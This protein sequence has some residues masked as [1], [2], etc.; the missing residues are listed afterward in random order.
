MSHLSFYCKVPEAGNP[1]GAISLRSFCK[2]SYFLWLNTEMPQ[3]LQSRGSELFLIFAHIFFYMFVFFRG[4]FMDESKAALHIS[5]LSIQRGYGIFDFFRVREGVLVYVED[6]LDRF[7]HSAKIMRLPVS[8]SKEELLKILTDLT[9][10]NGL[11]ETGTKMILTGGY[12][13][14]GYEIGNPNL[15]ILQTPIKVPAPK[16]L[17]I[18]TW[19]YVRDFPEA[20]TI[21][22][23]AGIWLLQK[24][25]EARADEVLYVKNEEVTEFP[26]CNFFIVTKDHT[27]KTAARN[28]LKGVTRDKV[29]KLA[30][31]H[32]QVEE[33]RLTAQEMR[34]AKEAFLT[35]STKRIHPVTSIDGCAVGDGKP[36]EITQ[37]LWKLLC[38][39]EDNYIKSNL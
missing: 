14:D 1:F 38:E 31:L 35:S 36:G 15:I 17:Q 26:R 20:K 28:V 3:Y 39:Y 23:C 29:L 25:K 33:G 16:P 8:Y 24:I 2:P 6:H 22:Y 18:I 12:S 4:D 5:D 13:P 7:F 34:E 30:K 27:V 21:N 9:R 37:H 10:K 11:P 19:D 32:Y